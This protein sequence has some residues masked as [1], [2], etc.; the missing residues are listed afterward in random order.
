MFP[1]HIPSTRFHTKDEV[2]T[3]QLAYRSEGLSLN[4]LDFA[5]LTGPHFLCSFLGNL[6]GAFHGPLPR[7]MY[8]LYA[9]TFGTS[10]VLHRCYTLHCHPLFLH[11]LNES[12]GLPRHTNLTARWDCERTR[13]I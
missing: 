5:K 11:L 4:S 6:K 3:G 13:M 8:I 2:K 1:A 9:Q 12:G 7:G 10:I